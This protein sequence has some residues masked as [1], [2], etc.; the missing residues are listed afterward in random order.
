MLNQWNEKSSAII[1]QT[2]DSIEYCIGKFLNNL[3]ILKSNIMLML[4]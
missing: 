4:M 2:V 1:W 3:K